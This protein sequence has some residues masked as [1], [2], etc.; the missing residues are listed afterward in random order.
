M[1]L[2]GDSGHVKTRSNQLIRLSKHERECVGGGGQ[3]NVNATSVAAG[4]LTCRCRK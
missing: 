1:E 2:E 4:A 3:P